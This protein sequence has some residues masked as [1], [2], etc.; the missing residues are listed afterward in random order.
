MIRRLSSV[1][2]ML[3]L[4]APLPAVDG[5]RLADYYDN[6]L[7]WKNLSTGSVGRLW[8]NRDGRYYAFYNLGPQPRPPDVN[9]PFQVEGR[10]GTYTVRDDGG[11]SRLCLWPAAPRT[12]LGAE[13]Q[14]ELFAESRCYPLTLHRVGD[15][16]TQQSSTDTREYKYWFVPGR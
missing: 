3:C 4:A 10:I 16:W 8:L 13:M 12:R 6:T 1:V 9:G 11:Q 15:S 7:I 2:L 5:P 14:H